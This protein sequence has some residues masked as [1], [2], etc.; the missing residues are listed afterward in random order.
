MMPWENIW[1]TQP[2]S[3]C[4]VSAAMPSRQKPMCETDE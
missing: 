2:V 3:P 4:G 1:K